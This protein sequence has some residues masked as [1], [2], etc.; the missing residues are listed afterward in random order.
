MVTLVE[1]ER[2]CTYKGDQVGNKRDA[3][4]TQVDSAEL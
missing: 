4:F 3:I 1:N 2:I